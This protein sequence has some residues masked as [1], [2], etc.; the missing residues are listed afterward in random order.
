[1]KQ[2][3]NKQELLDA[4]EKKVK[5]LSQQCINDDGA[6]QDVF[7]NINDIAISNDVCEKDNR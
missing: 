1:M 2:Y 3:S 6:S 5:S 4:L 7:D